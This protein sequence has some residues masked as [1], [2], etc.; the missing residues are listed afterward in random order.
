M[1]KANIINIVLWI[2]LGGFLILAL[3]YVY[4]LIL[5]F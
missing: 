1:N 4:N 5:R 2:I 3:L